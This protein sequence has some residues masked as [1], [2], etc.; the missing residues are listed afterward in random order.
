MTFESCNAIIPRNA[1]IFDRAE[2]CFYKLKEERR[3]IRSSFSCKFS[4]SRKKKREEGSEKRVRC[5]EKRKIH[6]IALNFRTMKMM[7]ELF[8]CYAQNYS[9]MSKALMG[10]N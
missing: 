4:A 6:K 3:R 2:N 8:K 5:F 9:T 7:R 10:P 1:V